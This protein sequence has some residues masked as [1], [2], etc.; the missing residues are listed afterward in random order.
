MR[1]LFRHPLAIFFTVAAIGLGIAVASKVQQ[2]SAVVSDARGAGGQA[3]L[4]RVASVSRE[5]FADRVESVGTAGANESVNLT[6][7]ISD[8][9]SRIAFEDGALVEEGDIL[10]ELTNA[11]E[12]ARLAEAQATADEAARQYERLKSLLTDNL[13]SGTDLD[14]ARTRAETAQARLEGVIVAMDNHL[15]RALFRAYSFPAC[16]RSTF[17]KAILLPKR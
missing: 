8:T 9:I 3:S 6:P 11:S 5:V 17:S 15:I 4:V 7:K 14:V 2:Q 12:A 10:V 16:T 1:F 13:I